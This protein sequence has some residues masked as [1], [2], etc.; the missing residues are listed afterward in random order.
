MQYLLHIFYYRD[1]I[2]LGSSDTEGLPSLD[3]DEFD[4]EPEVIILE[5]EPEDLN[6]IPEPENIISD[7]EEDI[8]E[9]NNEAEAII[10]ISDSESEGDSNDVILSNIIVKALADTTTPHL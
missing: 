7:D 8:E 3:S 6:V 5:E 2:S 9:E 4:W 1:N 10:I